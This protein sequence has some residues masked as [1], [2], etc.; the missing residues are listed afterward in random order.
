MYHAKNH[1]TFLAGNYV[2]L[3]TVHNIQEAEYTHRS[4]FINHIMEIQK[5]ASRCSFQ[6][7]DRDKKSSHRFRSLSFGHHHSLSRRSSSVAQRSGECVVLE[8]PDVIINDEDETGDENSI[9]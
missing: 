1:P 2:D 4:E 5:I 8:H 9:S 3:D 7:P 6:G